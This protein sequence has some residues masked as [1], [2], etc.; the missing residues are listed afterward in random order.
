MRSAGLLVVVAGCGFHSS[1]ASSPP[2]EDAA[3][4]MP[5]DDAGGVLPDALVP[6][7]AR[8]TFCAIDGIVACFEFEGSVTDGSGNAL[9]TTASGVSF[10]HNG[11]LGMA[12]QLDDNSSATVKPTILDDVEAVTIEAWIRPTRRP[13]GGEQ[14]NILDVDQQYAFT[15]NDDGTLT[16]DLHPNP[17][18]LS[19][20]GPAGTV[21]TNQWTHVACTYDGI[22]T[23]RIYIN[24]L[25]AATRSAS[26]TLG[27][28]GHGIGIAQNY[29]GGSQLIGL[30]DQ[31]RLLN[32]ARSAGDICT[33]SGG[34]LCISL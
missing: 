28:G 4:T 21:A 34:T 14:F 15:I 23:S 30:I 25:A 2:I 13:D 5:G 27:K 9:Q 12:M 32:V 10:V 8:S 3:P 11:E 24:G 29:P 26:G 16:C 33:D 22:N 19:T 1:A 31:L 17:G 20:T 6:D 7:A 18:K